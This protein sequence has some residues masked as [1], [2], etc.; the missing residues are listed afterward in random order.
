MPAH[1]H[2]T[3]DFQEEINDKQYITETCQ[4]N[5]YTLIKTCIFALWLLK[6]P[7][8]SIFARADKAVTTMGSSLKSSYLI[9]SVYGVLGWSTSTRRLTSIVKF[10][11]SVAFTTVSAW[12][13]SKLMST[14]KAR[15]F[16]AKY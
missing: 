15:S 9:T 5:K 10:M 7:G 8:G 2:P 16:R 4:K 14:L 12:D 11:V 1:R 3:L 13:S 6:N